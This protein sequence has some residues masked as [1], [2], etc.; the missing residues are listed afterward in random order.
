M[1]PARIPHATHCSRPAPLLRL[2]WAG[3]PEVWCPSCGRATPAPD[4]RTRSLAT[5]EPEDPGV[6]LISLP[7]TLRLAMKGK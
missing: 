1:S 6:D 4:T 7:R 5:D 2:S 3:T